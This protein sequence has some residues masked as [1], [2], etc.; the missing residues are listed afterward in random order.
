MGG[1]EGG[2][3]GLKT[4]SPQER[5]KEGE[6]FSK[7][8]LKDR[9]TEKSVSLIVWGKWSVKTTTVGVWEIGSGGGVVVM[10]R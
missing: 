10:S 1:G 3:V 5:I 8:R 4:V 2:E 6:V 7:V 9:S